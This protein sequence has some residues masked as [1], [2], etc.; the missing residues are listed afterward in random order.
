MEV[1][2]LVEEEPLKVIAT[3]RADG[4]VSGTTVVTP[5]GQP[6]VTVITMGIW[7]QV[8]VRGLRSFLQ[9]FVGYL[10]GAGIG[11]GAA[12]AAESAGIIPPQ[13]M[14]MFTLLTAAFFASIMPTIVSMLQ[15]ALE[16]LTKMD[17]SNP[18][19]RA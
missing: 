7:R 5:A 18:E 19:L 10:L 4:P 14:T 12:H 9:N 17:A 8:G 15:N 1:V 11:V 16:I 3:E 2:K 6:N 13:A